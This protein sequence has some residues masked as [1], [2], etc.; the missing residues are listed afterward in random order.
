MENKDNKIFSYNIPA[1]ENNDIFYKKF[2]R[3]MV[4]TL[5]NKYQKKFEDFLPDQRVKPLKIDNELYYYFV[6]KQ[7]TS[8]V[9]GAIL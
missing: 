5:V 6:D 3:F 8:Y 9:V 2:G 4:G 1:T 7:N